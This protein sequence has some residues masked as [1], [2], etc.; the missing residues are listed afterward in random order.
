M[1][2]ICVILKVELNHHQSG[3]T[4]LFGGIVALVEIRFIHVYFQ[5]EERMPGKQQDFSTC[6]N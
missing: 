3:L 1:L 5:K 2:K 4:A 6:S